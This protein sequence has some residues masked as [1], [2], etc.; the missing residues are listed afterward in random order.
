MLCEGV[1]LHTVL[2]WAFISQK[3]LLTGMMVI[4]WGIPV[5]TTMIYVPVR[6]FMEDSDES[7]M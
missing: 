1:Y 5:V 3:N 4:G 7:D 2:V 6:M